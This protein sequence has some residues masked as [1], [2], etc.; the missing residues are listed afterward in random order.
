M[1]AKKRTSTPEY[2]WEQALLDAYYDYRWHEVLDP[3]YNK[4]QR[5]KAGE[6]EHDDMDHAIHQTHKETRQLYGIFL[7]KREVLVRAIQF[8]REWFPAWVKDNPPPGG[9][10]LMNTAGWEDL[11][12]TTLYSDRPDELTD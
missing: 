4:F 11:T 1:S 9:Y 10:P 6:L 8:N 2:Q 3:L 5:W 7:Q 12:S